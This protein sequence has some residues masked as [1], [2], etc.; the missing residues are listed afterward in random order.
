[1]F[2]LKY[3]HLLICIFMILL[4]C[5]VLF[6]KCNRNNVCDKFTVGAP[7]T[8][9][10][11][12]AQDT[13]D[14]AR[15]GDAALDAGTDAGA[16][17]EAEYEAERAAECERLC[18]EMTDMENYLGAFAMSTPGTRLQWGVWPMDE[19]VARLRLET[20]LE[21]I[22]DVGCLCGDADEAILDQAVADEPVPEEPDP[23]AECERL[24]IE[25]TDMENYLGAFALSTPGTRLQW[26]VWPMD[27]GVARLRLETALEAISDVGCLCEDADEAILDQAVADEPV[28]EEPDPAAE[29]ERLCIEKREAQAEYSR[30]RSYWNSNSLQEVLD[31]VAAIQYSGGFVALGHD[32]AS[33]TAAYTD[34]EAARDAATL[35]A[36]GC[37]C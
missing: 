36:A 3:V 6:N 5:I 35:A 32:P 8:F 16:D 17:G 1:M 7:C 27:E 18:I 25:M 23:A 13:G 30:V 15:A 26:G 14:A 34:S 33:I 29:C 9:G 4:L 20:A 31:R 22:S 24:C 37:I 2:K 19:G 12:A 21:A 10:A 28:P 11:G